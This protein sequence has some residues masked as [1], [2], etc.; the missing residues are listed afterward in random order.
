MTSGSAG[1]RVL[2]AG[3]GD[4]F[5]DSGSL[6]FAYHYYDPSNNYLEHLDIRPISFSGGWPV[7][8][9]PIGG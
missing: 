8:G 9:N 4:V 6:K 2:D 1:S 5:S 3:G 7:F